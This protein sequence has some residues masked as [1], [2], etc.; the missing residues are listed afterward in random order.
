MA[1]RPRFLVTQETI[2]LAFDCAARGLTNTQIAEC[3]GLG[4]STLFHKQ[5]E[6]P[7]LKDAIKKGKAHGLKEVT[8]ALYEKAIAGD[9]TSIIFYLKNRD[10]E[11]WGEQQHAPTIDIPAINIVVDAPNKSPEPNFSIQ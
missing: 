9:N 6:F 10:R 8:N 3:L 2:N 1:G 5:T 11:S 7:E 4:Y